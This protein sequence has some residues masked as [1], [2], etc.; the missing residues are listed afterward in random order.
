MTAD[1]ALPAQPRRCGHGRHCH[2]NRQPQGQNR[3]AARQR[4]RRTVLSRCCHRRADRESRRVEEWRSGRDGESRPGAGVNPGGVFKQGHRGHTEEGSR[5]PAGVEHSLVPW[6]AGSDGSAHCCAHA[7]PCRAR[8]RWARSDGEA[9]SVRAGSNRASARR[10]GQ[11]D[12]WQAID[13]TSTAK[14]RARARHTGAAG[15]TGRAAGA[16]R[17]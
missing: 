11:Q 2:A 5:G 4:E 10:H 9:D 14:S 3:S 6:P 15:A 12:R 13:A 7:S 17:A 16:A 8:T 1:A